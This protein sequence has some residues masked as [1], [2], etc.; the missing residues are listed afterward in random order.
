ML[1]VEEIRKAIIGSNESLKQVEG[2]GLF[3]SLARGDFSSKSDID[4]F[5]IIP[6]GFSE[7]EAWLAW[8]KRLRKLLKDFKR[9]ITVL[10]YS[11]KS[12]KEISSWYVL[13]LAS[14]G[15][16]IYDQGGKIGK[17]F[18]KIIQAA[19]NAGLVEEEIHGYKY[20]IKKDLRIGETFE[21]KV[22]E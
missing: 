8:N 16:L 1:I 20:W 7:N 2:I 9:D 15:K 5:I 12:L 4:I 14:E 6:D 10:V 21:I 3:G 11:M 17:L 13:R 19:Q 18:E 22:G